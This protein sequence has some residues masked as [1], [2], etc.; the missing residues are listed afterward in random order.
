ME[1]NE[2][3]ESG[4]S[5]GDIFRTIFS[6]K[7]IALAIAVLITLAGTL[8]LYFIGKSKE[9]YVIEFTLNL[10]EASATDSYYTY[11]DRTRFY[12]VD[13]VS[14]KVL[15]EVKSENSAYSDI[16]IEKI[17]KNG[18]SFNEKFNK[19]ETLDTTAV[20]VRREFE[21]RAKASSFANED[22]ARSFLSEL[23]RYPIS[24]YSKMNINYNIYLN[25]K[26]FDEALTYETQISYIRQQVDDLSSRYGSLTNVTDDDGYLV[27]GKRQQFNAWVER[28][29]LKALLTEARA[30]FYLKDWKSS[31]EKYM[32][33]RVTLQESI[34]D[35]KHNLDEVTRYITGDNVQSDDLATVISDLQSRLTSLQRQMTTINSYINAYYTNGAENEAHIAATEAYSAKIQAIYDELTSDDGHIAGYTELSKSVYEKEAFISYL[36]PNV[37]KVA[38]GGTGI[39]MSLIISLVAGIIIACIVAYIVGWSKQRKI[40]AVAVVEAPLF[41]E[42]RAQT[43]ATEDTSDTAGVADKKDDK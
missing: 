35:A 31:I 9:E 17:V 8:A 32:N 34:D 37:I 15:E 30:N 7:W 10:P 28:V 22:L 36:T 18:I 42:A 38:E 12:Y 20:T 16:N 23:V 13:Y 5:I 19:V 4:I 21:I 26:D 24:Y 27:A 41:A 25:K 1:Y 6:Q 43:A 14:A 11:P 40:K 39:L 3:E 33:E 2:I 29:D